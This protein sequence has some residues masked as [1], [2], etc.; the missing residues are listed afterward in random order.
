MPALFEE[1]GIDLARENNLE[2]VL[3]AVQSARVSPGDMVVIGPMAPNRFVATYEILC[4]S[5]LVPIVLN[6]QMSIR[7]AIGATGAKAAVV[8]S[9]RGIEVAQSSSE[10]GTSVPDTVAVLLQTSGSTAAPKFVAWTKAGVA[11]QTTANA[12]ALSY[13]DRDRLFFAGSITSAYGLMMVHNWQLRGNDL[14]IATSIRPRSMA[15]TLAR[16]GATSVDTTP[17]LYRTLLSWVERDLMRLRFFDTVRIFVCGSDALPASL[18][19]RW[20]AVFNRPILDGYGLSEAGPLVS[21][22]RP[23]SFRVGT[24]GQVLAG[25]QLRIASDGEVLVNTPSAMHGYWPRHVRS[26][27]VELRDGWIHT[28]DL[29]EIDRDGFLA[30]TGR[31]KSLIIVN[32]NNVSPEKVEDALLRCKGVTGAGVLAATV[33]GRTRLVAF[34]TTDAGSL[35]R[36][37]LREAAREW[38]PAYAV[39]HEIHQVERLPLSSNSKL[40]RGML[41]AMFSARS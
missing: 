20:Y 19:E 31:K 41:R 37:R 30:I 8:E 38:L 11:Y 33:K 1:E 32:G 26:D 27:G 22:N 5:A 29:G 15:E 3:R 18:A 17:Q 40:D 9:G 14:I 10:I 21:I 28:G 4:R 34:V 36:N 6:G 16:H 2:A 35:N 7:E 12:E 23:T 24:A 39:P 25:T 13:G